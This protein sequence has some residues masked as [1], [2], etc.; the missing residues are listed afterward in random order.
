M[1]KLLSKIGIL[2][3]LM[4]FVSMYSF[5]ELVGPVP[6]SETTADDYPELARVVMSGVTERRIV[7]QSVDNPEE[8]Y[9]LCQGYITNSEGRDVPSA[10]FITP[11]QYKVIM[12]CGATSFSCP[13]SVAYEGDVVFIGGGYIHIS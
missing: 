13:S 4:L 10:Y 12:I 3:F 9:V 6:V 7:L 5:A 1:K 8:V 11:G 2:I